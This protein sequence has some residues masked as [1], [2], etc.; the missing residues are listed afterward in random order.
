MQNKNLVRERGRFFTA[1][2]P[3]KLPPFKQWARVAGL[4]R[5]NILEPFAGAN[6]IIAHLREM[7]LCENHRSFDIEPAASGVCK[8]D[9]LTSFPRGFDVCVTNPPWLA[10]N[11]A[12]A[13]GL[14]F[15]GTQYSDLYQLALGKCLENCGWV[16]AIIPESFIRSGLFRSRMTDFVG[17]TNTLFADTTHPV[18][19]AMF[20]PKETPDVVIWH[21]K[22]RIG[23][24]SALESMRPTPFEGGVDVRFNQPRGNVGLIALDNTIEPSI[25]F[26]KPEE[27]SD[28]KV[29]STC[30][31]ITKMQV[32]GRVCISAWNKMLDDFRDDTRDV[33]MNSFRGVR[34]DGMYRRRLDWAL[35]RGIV[36]NA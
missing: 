17:I 12:K 30:R 10:K 3:F 4:P 24:L 20:A 1:H 23:K 28:Y 15:P 9:T 22:I 32:S 18:G 16:A 2:N 7:G 13:Q 14:R 36:Q 26:C 8:R 29:N 19:L 21:N 27:L 25:R 33:L 31:S 5:A 34:R 6:M 11:R 35:A